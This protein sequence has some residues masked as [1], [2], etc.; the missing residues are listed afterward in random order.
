MSLSI[1]NGYLFNGRDDDLVVNKS[2]NISNGAITDL[3]S[4]A[5][6]TTVLDATDCYILPGLINAHV[7]L[8]WDSGPD[9]ETEIAD[10]P[11]S[12]VTLIAFREATKHLM[13]GITTLRDTGSVGVSVTA[14]RDAINA[15]IVNG[16]N[17][18][19]SGPPIA[20]TGGHIHRIALEADGVDKVRAAT[21]LNLKNNVDL[22]KLMATGGVYTE[23]EEPGS[24][25]LTM[26][27][28][29]A[30]VEETHKRGKKTA[31]H[32]EGL[33]GIKNA[34]LSGVDIIEHGNYADDEAIDMM[35][36][37]GAYLCPTNICFI[38]MAS[39]EALELGVPEWAIKKAIEVVEAQKVSFKKAVDAGVKIIAGTD[40]G[41]PLDTVD[42]YYTELG[43]MQ[44]NGMSIFE[45]LKSTTSLAA[46]AIGLNSVGSIEV[47]K[48]ADVLVV[49][50]DF[51]SDLSNL[52]KIRY[53]VK[54]GNLIYKKEGC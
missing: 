14:L 42:D 51:T 37:N 12:Y 23:G 6:S 11:D 33:E 29:K 1:V 43:I 41:A 27:E 48:M 20:M 26:E 47:G 32:A 35:I 30:A 25:Q 13:L 10:K 24:P 49:E 40:F 8:M 3:G 5:D 21:R 44:E 36:N 46:E 54:G 28:M 2:I 17:I 15:G 34:L 16:P 52:K 39:K 38:R 31:A 9:P 4:Q 53:I 7:H 45:I 22:I 18:L 19:A 50:G